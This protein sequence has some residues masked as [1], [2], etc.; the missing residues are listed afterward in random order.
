MPIITAP[1]LGGSS[2]VSGT[3][4]LSWSEAGQ[5]GPDD[6]FDVRVWQDGQP[7]TGIANVQQTSY[8]IGGSFPAG[9]YNWTIAVVRKQG[10]QVVTLA[11]AATV[12]RFTWTPAGSG[13]VNPPRR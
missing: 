1:V 4:V 7:A 6:Y 2:P 11:E 9:T 13:G 10:G 3:I 12:L 5:L 8:T